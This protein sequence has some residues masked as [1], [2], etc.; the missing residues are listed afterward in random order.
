MKKKNELCL[1]IFMD[2]IVI[3]KMNKKPENDEKIKLS[4]KIDCS[5]CKIQHKKINSR[6]YSW[7]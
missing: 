2:S 3:W 1:T 6:W 7:N 5:E 4:K